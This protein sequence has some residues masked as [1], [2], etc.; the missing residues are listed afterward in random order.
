VTKCNP[1][2][3]KFKGICQ[4]AD[5]DADLHHICEAVDQEYL[6]CVPIE[7]YHKINEMLSLS[8]PLDIKELWTA[9]P[10]E[11]DYHIRF[12]LKLLRRRGY[13]TF[14]PTMGWYAL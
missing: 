10:S 1:G 13:A 3:C 5:E 12:C 14:K 2:C 8:M 11:S 6:P 9:F 7:L 4:R